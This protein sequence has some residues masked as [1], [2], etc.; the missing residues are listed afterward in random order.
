M[1]PF[2][3]TY[4]GPA[5][6]DPPPSGWTWYDRANHVAFYQISGDDILIPFPEHLAA[7]GITQK[8]IDV[9]RAHAKA[10]AVAEQD[11]IGERAADH[12]SQGDQDA[13]PD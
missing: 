12:A 1:T 6:P 13:R 4:L 8:D 10:K 5:D 2:P 9:A 11:K 7:F 3:L